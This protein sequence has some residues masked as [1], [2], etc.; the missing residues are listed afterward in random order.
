MKRF[1]KGLYG[2][3]GVSSYLSDI[4]SYSRL[5]ALGLA[6]SVISTVFNQL[7]AMLGGSVVGAVFFLLIFL[8]G[9]SM[10]MAINLLGAYVHTNRLQ[11]V[12]FFGKFYEG[13]GRA[14]LPFAA[15]T[16]ISKLR[17]KNDM[18]GFDWNILG[19]VVRAAGRYAGSFDGWNRLRGGRGHGWAGRRRRCDGKPLPVWQGAGAAAA[20]RH[21]GNLRPAD[22]LY[23]ADPGGHFGRRSQ[24]ERC[25]G[26]AL[27]AACLPM[28]VVGLVSARWQTKASIASISLLSKKPDQFGKAMT[29][30]VMVET[31]AVLALLISIL[32]IF[33]IG[34][35]RYELFPIHTG[36]EWD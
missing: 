9:H 3:Y 13:G 12:E 26:A 14:Y 36:K 4:L 7:G 31:Y 29:L 17:R 20:S 11:F 16:S 30:P 19:I 15:N 6:T 32:S 21:P 25:K 24:C 33:G 22:R 35:C 27:L 28:A 5:L 8:I 34:G 10:N 2:L 1:L 18:N 23:R